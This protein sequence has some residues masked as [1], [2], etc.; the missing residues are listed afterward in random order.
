MPVTELRRQQD[1]RKWEAGEGLSAWGVWS[2]TAVTKNSTSED[3][4]APNSGERKRHL[5]TE[6]LVTHFHLERISEEGFPPGS[7]ER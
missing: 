6:L 2:F 5:L 3:K 4:P 1:E 7:P